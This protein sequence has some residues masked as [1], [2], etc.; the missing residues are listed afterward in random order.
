MVA[1]GQDGIEVAH[2]IVGI[3]EDEGAIGRRGRAI[4]AHA[5]HSSE[6]LGLR[7]APQRVFAHHQINF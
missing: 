4:A 7:D 6:Y 1:V 3:A 2:P 5:D